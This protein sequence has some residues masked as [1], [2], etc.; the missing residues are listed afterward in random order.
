MQKSFDELNGTRRR[1]LEKPL[2]KIDDLRRERGL[3]IAPD[4]AAGAEILELS[5]G[6]VDDYDELGA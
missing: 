2:L 3:A 6:L 5:D 1:A 4:L